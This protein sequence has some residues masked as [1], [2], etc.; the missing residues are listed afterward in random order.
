MHAMSAAGVDALLLTPGADLFYLTGFEHGHAMER[1]LALVIRGDGSTQW[2]VPAMNVPQV[3]PFADR[4]QTVF[5]WT[6]TDGYLTPLRAA[7]SG[8]KTI[9][10][11]DEA[12]SAFLMDLLSLAP[13]ARILPASSILRGLRLRKT[14]DE[15]AALRAVAR[16]V[17]DTIP[18]AIR[19]CR[20]GATEA[21]IDQ[22]LRAAMLRRDSGSFVAFT[23]VASGPNSALP[24]HETGRRALERGDVVILDFGTRG[25]VE[26][27]R[28]GTTHH[29]QLFGY[30][31]DIT[32]TCTAGEPID[33]K[34]REVYRVVW[35][36]QR[37][38]LAAARPGATCEQV[39]R[40]V[41]SVIESA[42]YGPCFV[43]RTGHGLGLQGHEP[44]YVR[45]GNTQPME[46]GMV[47][48]VE[49]GIYLPGRFGV[50]LEVVAVVTSTGVALLN[51]P[52]AA[53]L[54]VCV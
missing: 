22:A 48:T 41:R 45:T 4:G 13:G 38:G 11:D 15:I 14:A 42:G 9:A 36:A 21:Q 27:V 29:S 35:E 25:S 18:E 17:D 20:P 44:P 47:F 12:R 40:A 1:L 37:A 53:E 10:F 34:V 5:G 50:R 43:H 26:R 8:A 46:E 2:I 23:I 19:L 16:Q 39:D 31:S 28:N 33:P 51:A 30:Q 3:Q 54:P 7:L 32:I 6:D 24:H 52:S 49:P